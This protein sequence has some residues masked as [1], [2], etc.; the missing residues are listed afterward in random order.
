MPWILLISFGYVEVDFVVSEWI[1]W[2][3]WISL[4]RQTRPEQCCGM[5]KAVHSTEYL[6]VS[7]TLIFCNGQLL[8]VESQILDSHRS[9]VYLLFIYL[10]ANYTH[11]WVSS[12]PLA[13]RLLTS[14]FCT[15]SLHFIRRMCWVFVCV[16][17]KSEYVYVFVQ[18]YLH[19][20]MAVSEGPVVCTTLMGR[21]MASLPAPWACQTS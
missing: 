3:S 13:H 20:N 19:L 18:K 8:L 6:L 9:T 15:I 12:C 2:I 17:Q 5:C 4:F 16:W 11:R 14:I 1:S 10:L 21:T 7:G